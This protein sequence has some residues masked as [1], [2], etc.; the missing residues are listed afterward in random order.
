M[1]KWKF[2]K[3]LEIIWKKEKV[4]KAINKTWND[5]RCPTKWQESSLQASAHNQWHSKDSVFWLAQMT[6]YVM[7]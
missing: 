5:A 7:A 6:L 4:N 3:T 2:K 1:L